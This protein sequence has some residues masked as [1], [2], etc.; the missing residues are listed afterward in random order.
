[1]NSAATNFP[2]IIVSILEKNDPESAVAESASI[3]ILSTLFSLL[4]ILERIDFR[5]FILL[6]LVIINIIAIIF[7]DDNPMIIQN[8]ID[9]FV[10][11]NFMDHSI[12]SG[13]KTI[14]DN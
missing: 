13:I 12:I 8:S 5:N 7:A 6:I 11:E 2:S 4:L 1:M 10:N 3:K 14:L 9:E